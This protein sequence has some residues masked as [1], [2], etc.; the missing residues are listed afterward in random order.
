MK[1][2][3]ENEQHKMQENRDIRE[4]EERKHNAKVMQQNQLLQIQRSQML[5]LHA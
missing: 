3:N 1:Y 5:Q 2:E 4:A